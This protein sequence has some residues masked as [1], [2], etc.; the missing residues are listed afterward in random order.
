MFLHL[1]LSKPYLELKL[2]LNLSLIGSFA[3]FQLEAKE[4]S[5]PT[6]VFPENV[7]LECFF[8][9]VKQEHYYR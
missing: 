5:G 7:L 4:S 6:L 1:K 8:P 9:N 3:R 2:I